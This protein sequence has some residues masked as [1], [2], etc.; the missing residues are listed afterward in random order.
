MKFEDQRKAMVKHHLLA[1]GITSKNVIEA[2]LKVPR[3]YFVPRQIKHLSYNDSPLSIG[4]GQTISQPYIVALMM[5]LI[6]IQ[7][8][9]KI[10][11]IGTGSGYQ[12]ALLAEIAKEVNVTE[13]MDLQ[14]LSV[15]DF[16]PETSNI[17]IFTADTDVLSSADVVYI[18]GE[19]IVNGTLREILAIT[20]NARTR[21]VYGPTS[22]FYP[23]VLFN[24]GVDISLPFVFPTTAHFRRY[25]VSS[26]GWWYFVDGIKQL[27]IERSAVGDDGT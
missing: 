2:F 4:E 1:R 27:L 7:S 12:T 5:D 18:T 10:L 25:F 16:N 22:S 13:L 11:E 24:A 15:I 17:N 14:E 8:S 23:A 26:R 9:D 3:E 20:K 6:D 21:I 19:T